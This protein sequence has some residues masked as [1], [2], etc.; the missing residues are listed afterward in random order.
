MKVELSSDA[1]DSIFRDVLIQDY[2]SLKEDIKR[3]KDKK[4]NLQAY[5]K[6]DL[7]ANKRYKKA[8]EIMLEYYVGLDWQTMLEDNETSTDISDEY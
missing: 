7:K 2:K 3:L 1:V 5:Q 4:P 6:E 8:M